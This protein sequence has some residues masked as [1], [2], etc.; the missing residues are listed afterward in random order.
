MVKPLTRE[1]GA[2]YLA[3]LLALAFVSSVL[4]STATIWSQ[5]QQRE[6]EKQLLWAGDQFRQA[7]AAYARAGNGTYP[8]KLE[9][10]LEDPRTP[11][12]RRFLRRIYEDPM[13]RSTDWELVRNPLGAIIGVH[14][15]SQA[16][17]IKTGDFPERY[18][19]FE[20]ARTYA[21]WKFAAVQPK[22]EVPSQTA[23]DPQRGPQSPQPVAD[24]AVRTEERQGKAPSEPNEPPRADGTPPAAEKTTAKPASKGGNEPASRVTD[25]PPAAE[26][27]PA[28]PAS[29]GANEPARR[30]TD[31]PPA[32]AAKAATAK[33]NPEVTDSAQRAPGVFAPSPLTPLQSLQSPFA[34]GAFGT[35]FTQPMPASPEKPPAA[36]AQPATQPR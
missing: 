24:G 6:R 20:R 22:L 10:L 8:R 12:K 28:K 1:C 36:D 27:A 2:T 30:A 4:A 14:S 19:R 31:A 34:P 18:A 13:T 3:L 29:K 17:P 32:E 26:K 15:R 16:V 7:L 33:A 9:E 35:P 23:R 21:D 11:A 25:A 5:A